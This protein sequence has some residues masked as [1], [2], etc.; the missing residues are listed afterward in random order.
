VKRVRLRVVDLDLLNNL[1]SA[2]AATHRQIAEE[3]G[4]S[5]H[6]SVGRLM[7]GESRAIDPTPAAR[8]ANFFGVPVRDLFVPVVPSNS[9]HLARTEVPS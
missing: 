4:L 6:T 8:I 5:S 1:A 2:H 9:G 7:R 3:A